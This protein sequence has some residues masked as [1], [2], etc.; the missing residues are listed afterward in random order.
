[1]AEWTGI[2]G[3]WRDEP[4]DTRSGVEEL[5]WSHW[6]QLPPPICCG[7]GSVPSVGSPRPV[8]AACIAAL[9]VGRMQH[10]R[11]PYLGLL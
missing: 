9:A 5:L 11:L 4:A 3:N 1:M 6:P 10:S 2:S 7:A 8:T